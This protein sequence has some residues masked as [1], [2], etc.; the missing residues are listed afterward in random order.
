[1][2]RDNDDGV[3][4]PC[5]VEAGMGLDHDGDRAALITAQALVDTRAG[6][7]RIPADPECGRNCKL[8]V[9]TWIN[10]SAVSRGSDETI[11]KVKIVSTI[12]IVLLPLPS[13]APPCTPG[14]DRGWSQV[15]LKIQARIGP[16]RSAESGTALLHR[17]P[18]PNS[19]A[20]AQGVLNDVW[21]LIEAAV[22]ALSRARR[23][24]RDHD[25]RVA[26]TRSSRSNARSI[27]EK[28][29]RRFAAHA[30]DEQTTLLIYQSTGQDLCFYP[31]EEGI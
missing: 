2:D 15:D 13:G 21:L 18:T 11:C 17:Q 31:P 8:E 26:G 9:T 27:G 14:I 6:L 30:P 28:P 5:I 4:F 19:V 3:A 20:A 24:D 29:A 1:M 23:E 10:T 12:A 22:S 16:E 25:E 7:M